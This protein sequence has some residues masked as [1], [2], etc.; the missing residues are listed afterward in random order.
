MCEKYYSWCVCLTFY[1]H[2]ILN[3]KI[4]D[5][6]L[7]SLFLMTK[8]NLNVTIGS[9]RRVVRFNLGDLWKKVEIGQDLLLPLLPPLDEWNRLQKIHL[10]A[11]IFNC[12]SFHFA[13]VIIELN[14]FVCE[15]KNWHFS[16][17]KTKFSY[18]SVCFSFIS[19]CKVATWE[20][21]TIKNCARPITL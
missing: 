10:T 8:N 5:P 21:F 3:F 20:S 4:L 13:I 12:G 7:I 2:F 9:I 1:I 6:S 11:F 17:N 16:V 15:M 19:T 14:V 18:F